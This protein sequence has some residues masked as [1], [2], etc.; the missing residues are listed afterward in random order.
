VPVLI[1][2]G[3]VQSSAVYNEVFT[4]ALTKP[5]VWSKRACK[6]AFTN[7][8]ERTGECVA[9]LMLFSYVC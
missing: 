7:K 9:F 5:V 4:S 6:I 2:E 3:V 1:P 8:D